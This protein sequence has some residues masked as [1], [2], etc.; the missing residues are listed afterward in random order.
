MASPS[1][2]NA[3]E[4]N[5]GAVVSGVRQWTS[6]DGSVL[7]VLTLNDGD[8]RRPTDGSAFLVVEYPVAN[9]IQRTTGAPGANIYEEQGAFRIVVNEAR[10]AGTARA[11]GWIEELRNLF[12]GALFLSG[13]LRCEEAPPS[14]VNLASDLGNYFELSFAV[15]YSFQIQA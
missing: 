3:I 1:V 11:L 13:A 5:I 7:R 10:S 8:D 2:V 6:Q 9:E 12:R 14:V 15:P 4:G